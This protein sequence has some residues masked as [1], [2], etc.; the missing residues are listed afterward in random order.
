MTAGATASASSC[1]GADV[2]YAFTLAQNE[3]VYADTFGAGFDTRVGLA[4][5]CGSAATCNDNACAGSQSQVAT[6][7]PA[8]THYVVVGGATT[9]AFTLHVQ[10]VPVPGSMQGTLPASFSVSSN[11]TGAP[12]SVFTC[13]YT[14]STPTHSYYWLTCPTTPAGTATAATCTGTSW[15]SVLQF[16][17]GD[18]SAGACNDDSCGLQSS[19]SSA[20]SAGAGLHVLQLRGYGTGSYGSYTITGSHP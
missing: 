8:G 11:T 20:V 15:D 18:G 4:S 17:H 12:T 5:A 10:H 1:G 9:G 19:V 14:L 3:F 6:V 2:W 16:T 7:L 13:G